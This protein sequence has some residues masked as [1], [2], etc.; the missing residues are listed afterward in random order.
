MKNLMD[1]LIEIRFFRERFGYPDQLNLPKKFQSKQT[2]GLY[3]KKF[4]MFNVIKSLEKILFKS[5]INIRSS[6]KINSLKI[7]NRKINE[8]TIQNNS[9]SEKIK[10]ISFVLWTVP[11]FGLIPLLNLRFG[12]L[13]F[14]KNRK[15]IFVYI[16]SKERPKMNGS[17]YFMCFDKGFATFRVT[18]YFEYC[19]NSKIKNNYYPICM[20]MHFNDDNQGLN[21]KKIA[22]K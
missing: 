15:Q 12:N 17:Y 2:Y 21:Y 11:V 18:S 22:L 16:L 20:E 19:S 5:K 1:K 7:S 10:N 3:P 9:S 13:N 8:M 4:G 6:A 14:D